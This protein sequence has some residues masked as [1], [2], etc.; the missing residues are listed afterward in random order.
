MI[1]FLLNLACTFELQL[2]FYIAK[3]ALLFYILIENLTFIY[4]ILVKTKMKG[5]HNANYL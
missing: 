3:F 2:S 1:G 4:A 5:E